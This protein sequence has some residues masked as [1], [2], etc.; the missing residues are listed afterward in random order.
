MQL[1]KY[2]SQTF[3]CDTPNCHWRNPGFQICSYHQLPGSLQKYFQSFLDLLFQYWWSSRSFW[4]AQNFS[5]HV[6]FCIPVG[7]FLVN[8][9]AQCTV[10]LNYVQTYT[11]TLYTF[12]FPI[13]DDIFIHEKKK[14][15]MCGLSTYLMIKDMKLGVMSYNPTLYFS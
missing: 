2:H 13:N 8:S 7:A 6:Q 10:L 11:N 15:Q 5:C 14:D 4:P 12:P 1:V 9:F 3:L